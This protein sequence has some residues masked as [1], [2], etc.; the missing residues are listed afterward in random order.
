M[1]FLDIRNKV[2]KS[3]NALLVAVSKTRSEEQ[4]LHLYHQGQRI[5]GENRVQELVPKYQHL[6]KDIQWHLI[7]SLQ[8]N[9]VKYIAPFVSVI[10][11]VDDFELVQTID[12]EALKSKRT[13]DVLLQIK[14]AQEE[15]KQGFEY[16]ELLD[17][18][19]NEPW[20]QLKNIRITG[21]MGMASLTDDMDQV[22]DEFKKLAAYF[23]NIKEN[24]FS[25]QPSFTNISMGMSG[26][27]KIALEE[28]STMV[29]IGTA[30]FV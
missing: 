13:I 2:E 28:G 26:D 9:K 15:S 17:S 19:S 18:L 25:D 21:V 1:G 8:K 4:I 3:G 12:K 22:R 20:H 10:H 29:R 16:N 6:P 11:S 23:K 14:I 5:F 27:Y 30:L 24:F 7:G